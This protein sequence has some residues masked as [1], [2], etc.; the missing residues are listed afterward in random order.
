MATQ[1]TVA[2]KKQLRKEVTAHLRTLPPALVLEESRL[3]V[4]HVLAS[5]A[6]KSARNISIYLSTPIGE[7]QTD[8]LVRAAFAQ[9]E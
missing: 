5:T 3:V 1:I 6:W 2:A 4:Q 9:G 7:I 8:D